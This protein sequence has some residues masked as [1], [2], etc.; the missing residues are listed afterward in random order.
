MKDYLPMVLGWL[1]GTA[2]VLAI[3]HQFT[4]RNFGNGMIGLVIGVIL[5]TMMR[6]SRKS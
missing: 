2:I 4:W 3:T 5:V 6:R 1:T